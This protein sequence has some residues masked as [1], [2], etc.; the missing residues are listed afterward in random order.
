MGQYQQAEAIFNQAQRLYPEDE[1]ILLWLVENNLRQNDSQDVDRYLKKL[2][3]ITSA[4]EL[5]ESLERNKD[6]HFLPPDSK[7]VILKMVKS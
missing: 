7:A 2:L 1:L 4:E 5:F 6:K 3:E